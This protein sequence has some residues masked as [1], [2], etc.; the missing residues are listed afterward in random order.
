MNFKLGETGAFQTEFEYGGMEISSN[1]EIGFRPFQLMVASIAGCSGGVLKKILEKKRLS[2]ETI[3][4][5]ADI[6]R[7]EEEVNKISK[8][9]LHFTV[10]GKDLSYPQVKKSLDLATKNCSMIESVKGSIEVIETIEV[11][12]NLNDL[13]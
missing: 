8:I 3:H 11:R 4:I 10:V 9:A 1:T 7:I 6:T 2:F 12:E 13:E 5:K